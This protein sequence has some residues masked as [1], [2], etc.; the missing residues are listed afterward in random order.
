MKEILKKGLTNC[1]C[2]ACSCSICVE[3][4][5]NIESDILGWHKQ[6]IN[7]LLSELEN[8]MREGKGYYDESP[9]EDE[10]D[11]DEE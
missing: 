6:E 8:K 7:S 1:I 5:S 4:Q 2:T 10:D 3:Q 9:E 11:E